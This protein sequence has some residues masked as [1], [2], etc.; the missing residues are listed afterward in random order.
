MAREMVEKASLLEALENIKNEEQSDYYDIG[1]NVGV[2]DCIRVI[3]DMYE[4][5]LIITRL[6]YE[7]LKYFNGKMYKYIARDEDGFLYVYKEKPSKNESVWGTFYSHKKVGKVED[8]FTFVEWE[9]EEPFSIE[10]LICECEVLE[11]D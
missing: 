8:L 9:D 3:I 4:P 6:E 10:K 1:Y 7:L 2:E 11:D 5:K